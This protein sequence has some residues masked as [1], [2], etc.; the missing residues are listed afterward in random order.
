MTRVLRLATASA[1]S[2]GL[3]LSSP[4]KA[5]TILGTGVNAEEVA[6]LVGILTQST[7]TA[8]TV[9]QLLTKTQQGIEVAQET[10]SLLRAAS[11]V[12]VDFQY[13]STNPNQIFDDA[14]ASFGASFPELE[15]IARDVETARS[16]LAGERAGDPRTV[17]ELIA[18][19][20]QTTQGSYQT[21]ISFDNLADGH[22]SGYLR[23]V[24]LLKET[25]KAAQDLRQEAEGQ[26]NAQK[27]AIIAARAAA[28]SATAESQSAAA[29]LETSRILQQQ[30]VNERR[31]RAA[32]E[33]AKEK[34]AKDLDAVVPADESVDGL[35]L[36]RTL[37]QDPAAP[38]VP[39]VEGQQ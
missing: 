36:L 4:A 17:F 24:A 10:A 8:I 27:A 2:L 31:D 14:Q 13:L 38:V 20:R 9:D 7:Q 34:N 3:L 37:R 12:V 18:H 21:L 23:N 19:A 15:A 30:Y 32:K 26:I 5:I 33:L 6:A 35:K 28:V 22:L 1:A 11:E 16:N 29:N 39:T 25:A